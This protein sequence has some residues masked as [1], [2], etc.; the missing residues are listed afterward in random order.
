MCGLAPH[1]EAVVA[2]ENVV[3]SNLVDG[4]EED[5]GSRDADGHGR[6]RLGH[7]PLL[8]ALAVEFEVDGAVERIRHRGGDVHPAPDPGAPGFPLQSGRRRRFHL[9]LLVHPAQ[10]IAHALPGQEHISKRRFRRPTGRVP[11]PLNLLQG[12]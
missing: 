2:A 8:E 11:L 4:A 7:A 5:A 6:P 3:A 12:G 9:A 1:L 10:V